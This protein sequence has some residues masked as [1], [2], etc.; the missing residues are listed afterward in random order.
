MWQ[1][2]AL[3]KQSRDWEVI[4]WDAMCIG[5]YSACIVAEARRC[6]KEVE[7]RRTGMVYQLWRDQAPVRIKRGKWGFIKYFGKLILKN[8]LMSV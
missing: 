3:C 4:I 1:F 8:V 6:S 7:D 5:I 2:L